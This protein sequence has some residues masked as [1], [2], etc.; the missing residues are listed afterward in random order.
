MRLGRLG[1]FLAIGMVVS[2][3]PLQAQTT[4]VALLRPTRAGK[5]YFS[6][7]AVLTTI[8][9]DGTL[10]LV[11]SIN[12]TAFTL[13]AGTFTVAWEVAADL[14][15]P[16]T[17]FLTNTSNPTFQS[18][19]GDTIDVSIPVEFRYCNFRLHA[20]ANEGALGSVHLGVTQSQTSSF[21]ENG[22]P[23]LANAG[24]IDYG[25]SVQV[26]TGDEECDELP[27]AAPAYGAQYTVT[28]TPGPRSRVVGR[29]PFGDQVFGD[30]GATI[31]FTGTVHQALFFDDMHFAPGLLGDAG[32]ELVSSSVQDTVVTST[33][34]VHN[35]TGDSTQAAVYA[36]GSTVIR[37]GAGEIVSMQI[38]T[39]AGTCEADVG[40]LV[41]V[42]GPGES[43]EVSI[44]TV[45]A[46][47]DDPSGTAVGA[48]TCGEMF[49]LTELDESSTAN[50]Q[51]ACGAGEIP[52][53]VSAGGSPPP[54]QTVAAGSTD[55]PV[56]QFTLTPTGSASLSSITLT[57]SGSG[58]EQVDITA[59]RLYVDANG[60]GQVDGAES[61]I[62]TGTFGAN[63][64]SVTLTVSPAY[65]FNVPT[66][67][68]VTYDF[69]VTLA[70]RLGG[71]AA[72]AML[73]LLFWPARRRKAWP[74]LLV[75]LIAGAA[76][77]SCGGSDSNG[78]S[79]NSRTFK[80]TLTGVT[81]S[82]SVVPGV[83][84]PGATLTVTK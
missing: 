1:A 26:L 49:L 34:R 81:L 40:C 8:K 29:S 27:D 46:R 18:V 39:P 74:A 41:G 36:D 12:P 42:L 78:P 84:L 23:S 31:R 63:N 65:S 52:V 15:D 9:Q 77:T 10:G 19:V 56:L 21:D 82:G 80:A 75:L 73:P 32:I 51:A 17:C 48:N 71:A 38:T 6:G 43:A 28:F 5:E 58:N 62:A 64:G 53:T 33:F 60:N 2:T 16:Y 66:T 45:T 44:T 68:L 11:R 59:V 4:G 37:A 69:N 25:C 54:N 47:L 83:S 70:E 57:A 22:I 79:G 24:A 35:S 7:D 76:I 3:G 30:I 61:A 14:G 13:G 72:L 55:V 20:D 67:F 50:N